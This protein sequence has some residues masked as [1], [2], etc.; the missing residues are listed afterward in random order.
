MVLNLGHCNILC[1]TQC[2]LLSNHF[3]ID[4]LYYKIASKEDIETAMKNGVNYPKG[5]F[6]W[7][8]EIGKKKISTKLVALYNFYCEE[9]YRLSPLLNKDVKLL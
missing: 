3:D 4:T 1:Y 9:R 8:K 2:Q 7:E 5:L 6:E